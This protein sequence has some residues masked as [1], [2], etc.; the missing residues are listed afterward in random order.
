MIMVSGKLIELEIQS[1]KG[2]KKGVH[3]IL[4]IKDDGVDLLQAG[5]YCFS[6]GLIFGNFLANE[7]LPR[8][9]CPDINLGG[10]CPT[11]Q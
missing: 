2:R 8:G 4:R 9:R 6:G 3:S 7:N 5:D 11:D 1:L 10:L